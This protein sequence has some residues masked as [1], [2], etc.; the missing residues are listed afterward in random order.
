MWSAAKKRARNSLAKTE[1]AKEEG[2]RNKI[3]A[4]DFQ[5]S[6]CRR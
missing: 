4:R 6:V 3:L 2:E 5:V 1:N